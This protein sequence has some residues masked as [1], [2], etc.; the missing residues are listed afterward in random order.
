MAQRPQVPRFGGWT[1]EDNVPYTAYFEKARKDRTGSRMNPNA[2]EGNPD[3]VHDNNSSSSNLPP[4]EPM[5]NSE[6]QT[7]QGSERSTLELQKSKDDAVLKPSTDS[8]ARHDN[9]GNSSGNDS[10][11]IRQKPARLGAGS[12][13]SVD[14]SPLHRL[15]KTPG[16]DSPSLE[17]RKNSNDSSHG[18]PG[19]SRLRTPTRGDESPDKAAAVPRFGAWDENDPASADGFTQLFNKVRE[20][21]AGAGQAPGTPTPRPYVAGNQDTNDKAKSCCFGWFN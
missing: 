19:R 2:P 13:Y 12:E 11:D 14:R 9:M 4:T 7:G 3:L 8:P 15:A 1:N 20:E 17:G 21:R 5:V 16:R 6:D 10:A 18:T